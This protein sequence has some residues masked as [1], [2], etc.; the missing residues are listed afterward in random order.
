MSSKRIG[1]VIIDE[2]SVHRLGYHKATEETIGYHAEVRRHFMWLDSWLSQN[3][4]PGRELSLA[5]TALQEA[6]LWSNAAIACNLAPVVSDPG[7]F[8]EQ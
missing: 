3:L 1:S 7:T 5:R 6:S 8:D 2:D 4:P